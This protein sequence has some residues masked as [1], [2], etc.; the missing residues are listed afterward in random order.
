[1]STLRERKK[2]QTRE[3]LVAAA[4]EAFSHQGFD[5]T[6]V[7]DLATRAGVSQRT[8]F[9]YF[10]AKEDV[11]F[12][13]YE[14]VFDRWEEAF[15]AVP[16][17]TTLGRALRTATVAA[18]A[19][20]REQPEVYGQLLALVASEPVLSRRARDFDVDAQHRAAALIARRTGAA[21]GDITPLLVAAATMGAVDAAVRTTAAAEAAVPKDAV[22]VAFDVLEGLTRELGTPLRD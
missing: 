14:A 17:G 11:V 9:R 5:R 20:A 10:A 13:R 7:D 2:R 15:D 1:M 21:N 19:A 4:L 3:A 16:A 22:D 12:D 18:S 8:F 6:T